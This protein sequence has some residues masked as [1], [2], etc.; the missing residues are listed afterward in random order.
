MPTYI[1]NINDKQQTVNVSADMPLLWILRDV[2]GYKGTK[3]GCG[4]GVCGTCTVLING[5]TE[6]SCQLTAKKV[7]NKSITT[8]EGLSP[9]GSHPVQ[10]AWMDMN[11]PQCGYCQC[12][13]ILTA[14]ALLNKNPH[15]GNEEIEAAMSKVYCRC[16]TYSRIKQAIQLLSQKVIK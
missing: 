9:D 3:F 12:G 1:L 11:V 14:V 13:Q 2:L 15:P 7:K 16:G 6:R 4:V 8:I 10:T 5:T